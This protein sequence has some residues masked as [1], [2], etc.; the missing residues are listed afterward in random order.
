MF[1]KKMKW[2]LAWAVLILILCAIPGRDIPHISFLEL[3]EFDKWVHAGLFFVLMLF[4]VRGM[5]VQGKSRAG[6]IKLAC[7][8]VC[9]AYG[10]ALELMQG[11]VFEDRAPDIY[12]F[13]A[14]SFGAV[15]GLVFYNSFERK[16]LSRWIK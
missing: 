8:L 2:A 3:L 15:M 11:A 13:I 6:K 5:L 16:L 9:I 14:N 1:L 10:G 4:A 12:D 7:L